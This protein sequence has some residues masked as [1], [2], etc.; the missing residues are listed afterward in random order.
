MMVTLPFLLLLLDYW[1]L[2]R[3]S[4]VG[5]RRLFIEK[6]PFFGLAV[7]FCVVTIFAQKAGDAVKPLGGL[8]MT[9]RLENAVLSYAGYLGHFFWPLNLTILYSYPKNF[10][11]IQV[12]LTT[13]LLLAIS[14]LCL[15]QHARRPYL[16]VG[17]FWYLGT[18]VPVI[19]LVQVGAEPMADRYTYIPLIGPVISLTWL[20]SEWSARS[21]LRR[22]VTACLVG[23][24][25]AMCIV[26]TQ[27][28]MMC[29]QN[30]VTLYEHAVVIE[31]GNARVQRLLGL[32]LEEEGNLRQAAVRYRM[33][34]AIN[35]ANWVPHFRLA[36][37]L[38]EEGCRRE[39]RAEYET[40]I[41]HGRDFNDEIEDTDLAIALA[42]L[43]RYQ[44]TVGRLEAALRVNPYST[45]AMNA[46]AWLL[47]TCPD[48]GIRDGTRAVELAKRACD[49]TGN[50]E[51]LSISTLAAADA[52][53]GH[54]DE[55]IAAGRE[56]IALGQQRGDAGL[57]KRNQQY[58]QLYMAHKA[59]REND[60]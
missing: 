16:L 43:G 41:S 34:I 8:A 32:G 27:A 54:F 20:V 14:A 45:K 24:A 2:Q 60:E 33:S 18:M 6:I 35:P 44:E 37:C 40:A 53:A 10:D 31:P 28:Q 42:R 30:V 49:M 3:F 9:T 19:G 1:P 36:D 22:Y 51:A 15:L 59:C 46:L 29:W 39:A 17:W 48:A 12:C 25:L 4:G 57:V 56:A 50:T 47:A 52:E 26:L 13:L 38:W 55:A 5:F 7:F 21:S 58:L 11:I 23:V